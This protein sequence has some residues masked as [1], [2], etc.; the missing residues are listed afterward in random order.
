MRPLVRADDARL[1]GDAA[2]QDSEALDLAVKRLLDVLEREGVVEDRLVAAAGRGPRRRGARAEQHRSTHRGAAQERRARLTVQDGDRL[3]ERA[4]TVEVAER[5]IMAHLMYPDP[6]SVATTRSLDTGGSDAS[7]AG[8]TPAI[9][10]IQVA[11][12]ASTETIRAAAAS[13]PFVRFG[14]WAL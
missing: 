8:V 13:A 2:G 4:I 7:G 3:L 1:L 12:R 9:A 5:Q 10:R 6:F 14:A 11:C